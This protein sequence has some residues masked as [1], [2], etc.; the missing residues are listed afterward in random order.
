M[1]AKFT[2]HTVS[3]ITGKL[4]KHLRIGMTVLYTTS[5]MVD[6]DSSQ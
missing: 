3:R 6:F 5:T 1:D 4:H 2:V